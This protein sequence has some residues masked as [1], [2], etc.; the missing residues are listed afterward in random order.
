MVSNRGAMN[1]QIICLG[2]GGIEGIKS[3]RRDVKI[4]KKLLTGTSE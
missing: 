4:V 1:K 2:R 3:V